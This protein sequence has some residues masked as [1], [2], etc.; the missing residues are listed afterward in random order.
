ME[1]VSNLKHFLQEIFKVYR[2]V[3]QTC[4]ARL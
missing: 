2:D 1:D 4:A 3:F